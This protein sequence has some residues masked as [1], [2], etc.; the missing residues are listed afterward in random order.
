[1]GSVEE[2]VAIDGEQQRA[3]VHGHSVT[4]GTGRVRP[5]VLLPAA[6]HC[7]ARCLTLVQKVNRM[8][9]TFPTA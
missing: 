4:V 9:A 5:G 7:S 6:S 3:A 8:I 2:A 1:M